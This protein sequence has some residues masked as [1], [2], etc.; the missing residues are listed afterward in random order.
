MKGLSGKFADTSVQTDAQMPVQIEQ[1]AQCPSFRTCVALNPPP[2]DPQT[3]QERD[4]AEECQDFSG[5]DGCLG[6]GPPILPQSCNV[7]GT[8]ICHI[9][10][11]VPVITIVPVRAAVKIRVLE[12][13]G[14]GFDSEALPLTGVQVMTSPN[15]G[16]S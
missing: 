12:S 10:R 3:C 14:L 9:C 11:D 16:R 13:L 2:A 7:I 8:N 1:T 5:C 4:T 15:N 6:E